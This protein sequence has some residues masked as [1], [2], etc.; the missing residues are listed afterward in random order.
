MSVYAGRKERVDS[1]RASGFEKRDL[2]I[3]KGSQS[4]SS[5][6]AFTQGVGFWDWHNHIDVEWEGLWR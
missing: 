5:S 1:C 2:G 4:M 6:Q 3:E